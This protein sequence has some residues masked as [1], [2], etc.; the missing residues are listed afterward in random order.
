MLQF[1][2]RL[3]IIFVCN[4]YIYV[5]HNNKETSVYVNIINKIK[6]NCDKFQHFHVKNVITNTKHM[7]SNRSR[8]LY[9]H[10]NVLNTYLLL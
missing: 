8:F 9:A 4:I 10:H 5:Y 1:I 3:K 7:S 2:F 6:L